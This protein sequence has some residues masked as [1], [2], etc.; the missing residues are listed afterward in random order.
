MPIV[1]QAMIDQDPYQYLISFNFANFWNLEKWKN[2]YMFITNSVFSQYVPLRDRIHNAQAGEI[3]SRKTQKALGVHCF[4]NIAVFF[5]QKIDSF[6]SENMS[7]FLEIHKKIR[8][9]E[10]LAGFLLATV[11]TLWERP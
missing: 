4:W 3:P 7:H 5:E 1:V 10:T 8:K 6:S 2:G 11:Y 9:I